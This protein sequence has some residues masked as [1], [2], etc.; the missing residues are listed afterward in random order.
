[1]AILGSTCGGKIYTKKKFG[2]NIK[3][4][5]KSYKEICK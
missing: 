5:S 1:M 2:H 4:K 3:T